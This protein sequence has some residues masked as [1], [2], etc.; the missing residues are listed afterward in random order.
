MY[1]LPVIGI[2]L[3]ALWA[4]SAA[5]ETVAPERPGRP[6]VV[7]NCPVCRL[8]LRFENVVV[9]SKHEIAPLPGGVIL[10]YHSDDPAVIEPLI[11]MANERVALA[12]ALAADPALH[13]RLGQACSHGVRDAAG[14]EITVTTSARGIF[15]IMTTG[16]SAVVR[17][18]RAAAQN[19][20]RARVPLW[21]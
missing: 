13:A 17:E 1:R 5:A 12:E 11:R 6:T 19:A 7:V 18:L 3:A 4:S 14:I 20:V 10:F 16:N 15:A 2:V 21:F 8:W 9:R